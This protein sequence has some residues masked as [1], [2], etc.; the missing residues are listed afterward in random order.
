MP[1]AQ[2]Q[3]RLNQTQRWALY[4]WI[5][6]NYTDFHGK[7]DSEIAEMA[8]QA[9]GFHVADTTIND[10]RTDPGIEATWRTSR[11]KAPESPVME[12]TADD[13][14]TITQAIDLIAQNVNYLLPPE[15]IDLMN[16]AGSGTR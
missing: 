9:L 4:K 16:R 14:L 10:I 11:G 3:L 5:D 7:A 6:A 13:I 1:K 2:R 12:I 15:F 8:H